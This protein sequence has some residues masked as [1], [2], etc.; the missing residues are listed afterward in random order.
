MLDDLFGGAAR[1]TLALNQRALNELTRVL[2]AAAQG[3][4]SVRVHLA[5]AGDIGTEAGQ[6][7]NQLLEQN[8]RLDNEIQRVT[9]DHAAG[10]ID[11]VIDTS[12]LGGEFRVTA[13]RINDLVD[14]HI[15][16]KKRALAVFDEFGRGNFDARIEPLPGKKAF[17]NQIIDSV[18]ANLTGLV[19][20]MNRVSTAHEKG[21]IDEVIDGQRFSGDFRTTAQRINELVAAHIAVKRQA[22]AVFDEF[23]RG[24]FAATMD[25]LPGKKAF[26]NRTI[27]SV[28]G[29]LLGLIAEMNRMALA[30]ERGDIDEFIDP[31]KFQGDFGTMARGVNEMVAAHI[32][33]KKQAMG[34]IDELGRGHF[35]APMA[36]LPGKKAFI[37]DTVERVRGLFKQIDQER[38]AAVRVKQALDVVNASVMIA[39]AEGVI[40]YCNK[41]VMQM[42]KVAETDLKRDLPNFNSD[43][44]LGSNFDSF[45]KNPAH[46]RNLL[47]MVKNTHRAE[48]KVGGR[49]FSLT[50]TPVFEATGQRTGTVVEWLDRTAEVRVVNEVSGIVA[51]AANGQFSERVALEGKSG[52]FLTLS[53]GVNK[54]MSATEANLGE[55][56]HVLGEVA[57]GNLT[58]RIEGEFDGI[59]GQ[60]QAD[61][62]KMIGQLVETI[63]D[64]N[65]A[66]QQLNSAAG[67]VSTTSQSLSQAAST[68]AAGVEETTASLQEMASSIRQNSESASVTDGMAT[69]AAKEAVEGGDAVGKTVVAMKQ[70]ATKISIIDDIAYQTNLL[71]LNAAIEAARAGEHG[72]GFAVV[73]AEVRKLAERSQVAAQEIGELAGSSVQMAERAG[74]LL[75]QMVP[76]IHKTSELVQEIAAA[77]GEQAGSVNQI[78]TAMGHLNSSTQQNASASEELS[79]TAQ[80]MSAQAGQLQEMMR[81][82]RIEG[83]SSGSSAAVRTASGGARQRRLASGDGL[84]RA[85]AR[86]LDFDGG[87]RGTGVDE[88]S[89]GR[90]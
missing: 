34:V 37:N 24:N 57:E 86:S 59:F 48:I 71:A 26:I 17:I 39:D 22:M 69:K 5:E 89:F 44:V 20:E 73:A 9:A 33:V 65:A 52:F 63:S 47:G 10:E 54:L 80:E 50:A 67:Q 25:N 32:A 41:S 78:T 27:E 61:V 18:R 83:T 7:L 3:D 84:M 74:A 90:F 81:F 70:I 36:Q 38:V 6:F 2:A 62:N 49:T 19:A 28:R 4:T 82:F 14:A 51:G 29:N 1:Q 30:H 31:S 23:G 42:L 40:R 12:Q 11:S 77:S 56:S 85:P 68:Q 64:V 35:D 15:T 43:E 79:A 88:S 45:H 87:G 75:T 8:R 66:A 60:L 53:E 76:S 16:M 72:K 58:R 46:Q 13:K 55:V 21:E